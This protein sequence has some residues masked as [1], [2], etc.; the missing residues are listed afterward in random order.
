MKSA[1]SRTLKRGGGGSGSGRGGRSNTAAA[2]VAGANSCRPN[3]DGMFDVTCAC[4]LAVCV[5]DVAAVETL[6]RSHGPA[7]NPPLTEET[8]AAL[9][10]GDG[11]GPDATSAAAAGIPVA[12]GHTSQLR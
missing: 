1:L 8:L 10:E 6:T 12:T 3:S 4:R 2:A 11:S 7:A 5:P 9:S